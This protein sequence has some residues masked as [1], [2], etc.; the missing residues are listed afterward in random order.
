ME[1]AHP[2]ASFIGRWR[3][4]SCVT[5]KEVRAVTA[6]RKRGFKA[7]EWE[8]EAVSEAEGIMVMNVRVN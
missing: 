5:L 7:F 8:V 3:G 4:R 2:K 1:D 6:E